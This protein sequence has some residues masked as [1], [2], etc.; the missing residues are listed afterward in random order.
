MSFSRINVKRTLLAVFLIGLTGAA[1]AVPV[2]SLDPK[3]SFLLNTADPTGAIALDAIGFSL[4]DLGFSAGDNVLI[5]RVGDYKGGVG[6]NSSTGLPFTDNQTTLLAVFSSSS[7]LLG[8]LNLNRLPGAVASDSSAFVSKVTS[9][10][11][12]YFTAGLATDIAQD[13]DVNNGGLGQMVT[14]PTGATY[15]FFS[16]NDTNFVDNSDP[17]GNYGVSITAVPEPASWA[18]VAVGLSAMGYASRRRKK[19]E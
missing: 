4:A 11:N 13:F 15:I 8:R 6:V 9:W 19:P 1:A 5:K 18:L 17:N 7:T 3:A 2:L 10:G 14:I 12:P 16:P